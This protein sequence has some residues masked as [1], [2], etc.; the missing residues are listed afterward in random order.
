MDTQV[1]TDLTDRQVTG[2]LKSGLL[3]TMAELFKHTGHTRVASRL[4]GFACPTILKGT[5]ADIRPDLTCQ[6]PD[7]KSTPL[8]LEV[9]T[10]SDYR[11]TAAFKTRVSLLAST[12]R[13]FGWELHFIVPNCKV[14]GEWLPEL[15]K[16]RLSLMGITANKIW[17]A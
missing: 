16:A 15:L 6:Q 1:R 4:A 13:A 11:D 9:V 14:D 2:V 17:V 8:M 12:R 7:S 3:L 10:P 5:K